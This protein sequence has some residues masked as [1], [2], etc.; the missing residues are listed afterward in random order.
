MS[1]TPN[2]GWLSRYYDKPTREV[3]NPAVVFE[4][5]KK[6]VVRL[7]KKRTKTGGGVAFVGVTKTGRHH[8]SQHVA[9]HE[10]PA[11]KDDLRRMQ[12]WLTKADAS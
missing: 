9:L 6:A 4:G 10:G 11:T 12:D 8:V 3:L 5:A 2:P 1:T 7:N